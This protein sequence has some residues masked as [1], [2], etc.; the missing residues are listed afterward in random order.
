MRRKG[1]TLIELLVVIAIIAI[2]AAIL[3]PVFAKA[4]DKA[5]QAACLSNVK[6]LALGCI[7]Y[8]EDYDQQFPP[9]GNLEPTPFTVN[10]KAEDWRVQ[11]SWYSSSVPTNQYYWIW[12]QLVYPY[13]KS[14]QIVFCPNSKNIMLDT[15]GN[16]ICALGGYGCNQ[17]LFGRGGYANVSQTSW[18]LGK[19]ETVIGDPSSTFMLFDSGYFRLNEQEVVK[20]AWYGTWGVYLPGIGEIAPGGNA[21]LTNFIKA[22]PGSDGMISRH[23]GGLN[24]SYVDGHAKFMTVSQMYAISCNSCQYAN[25]TAVPW[26]PVIHDASTIQ[27]NW[28]AW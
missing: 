23:S 17:N 26:L 18:N 10:G 2:L 15:N 28:A 12:Q 5:R 19:N 20:P 27:N 9:S 7:M 16:Q 25:P 13:T 24:V 21:K 14:F 11:L 3:F 8:M 4:R 1:F 6:Q 22:G